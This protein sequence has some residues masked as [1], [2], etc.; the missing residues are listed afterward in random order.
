M[1]N[2]PNILLMHKILVFDGRHGDQWNESG[3]QYSS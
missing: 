2:Y 1:K 3:L